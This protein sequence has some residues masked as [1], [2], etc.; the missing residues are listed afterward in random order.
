MNLLTNKR[1]G[2]EAEEK[3][4]RKRCAI[5]HVFGYSCLCLLPTEMLIRREMIDICDSMTFT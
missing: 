1:T 4:K 3:R 5:E 2:S